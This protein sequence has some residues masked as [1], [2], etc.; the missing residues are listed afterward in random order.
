MTDRDLKTVGRGAG[1]GPRRTLVLAHRGDARRL[2]ENT[3]DALLA[4]L[5]VPGCDGLEL[6]VRAARDGTPVLAHD[7][8]LARVFGRPERVAD[9]STADLAAVG[10]PTL[11]EVVEAVPR[12]AFLDV[13]LKQDVGAAVVPILRAAR[14]SGLANAV[15]SS[16]DHAAVAAVRRLAPDWPA[17]L[18]VVTL[19]GRAIADAVALGARGISAEVATIDAAGVAEA[20]AAGLDVAAWTVVHPPRLA[21]LAALGVV[22]VCVEDAALDEG[23]AAVATA[24]AVEGEERA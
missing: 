15:V 5:T 23:G 2:P 6:D 7:E 19:D 11:R 24:A 3:I 10:V 9:L 4:A 14:G 12:R 17:W 13:E 1:G 18:N 16:F 22:A 20:R 8:T 21:E